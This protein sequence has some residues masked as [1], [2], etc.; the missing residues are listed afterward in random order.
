MKTIKKTVSAFLAALMICGCFVTAFA[1]DGFTYTE[2]DGEITVTGCSGGETVLEIP[3]EIDGKPV[4]AIGSWAFKE[5]NITSVTVPA[6]VKTIGTYAFLGCAKLASVE[7]AENSALETIEMSAFQS[8]SSLKSIVIPEGTRT[9]GRTVFAGTALE[10]ITIPASVTAFY[11]TSIVTEHSVWQGSDGS[12]LPCEFFVYY[13]GTSA[14][15]NALVE[16]SA[17]YANLGVFKNLLWSVDSKP[18]VNIYLRPGVAVTAP[19]DPAKEHY[20]F[21]GWVKQG[22]SVPVEKFGK[23]PDSDVRYNAKFEPVIFTAKFV[24]DGEVKETVGFTVGTSKL[25]EPDVPEKEG[26]TGAWEPYELKPENITINAV[27]TVNQYTAKFVYEGKTLEIRADYGSPLTAPEVDEK[28]GYEFVWSPEVPATMPA[29]DVTFTGKYVQQIYEAKL[30]ANGKQVGAV[31]YVYGQKSVQLPAVPEKE[32]YTGRWLPYSLPV[33][34]T[35]IYAEY[36]VNTYTATFI[37]DGKQ[38]VYN[39]EFGSP[40]KAPAVE[41]PQG[42]KLVW[43]PAVPA[44][45]PAKDITVNGSF[46]CVSKVSILKNTGKRSVDYGYSLVLYANASDLPDGAKLVWSVTGGKGGEG[47]E[48]NTGA[49]K[50]NRT[51]TLKL[52]G[53]DGKVIKDADGKEI[54]DTEEITVNG[55]FFKII[56]WFFKNLFKSNLTV[57]QK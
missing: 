45:M 48:Y 17:S 35:E 10:K 18:Y 53:K 38:T 54:K 22:S 33:G 32:G 16:N 19:A 3:G 39:V 30:F 6:S 37:V 21:K 50:E 29:K 57:Y 24:A 51:V 23:M 4:T 8:C 1:A 14:Q 42:Y 20:T 7:F 49:L 25:N 5:K 11:D 52:V 41:A 2:T 9:V 56:I 31:T 13:G 55:G 43:S 47:S 28:T 46:V 36:T 12:V 27:Y 34:G 40:V 26:Y 15:W 44:T